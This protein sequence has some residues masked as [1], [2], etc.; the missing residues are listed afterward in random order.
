MCQQAVGNFDDTLERI[1]TQFYLNP[2]GTVLTGACDV[3]NTRVSYV[4]SKLAWYTNNPANAA[5]RAQLI[6][7][8][9]DLGNLNSSLSTYKI[10]SDRLSGVGPMSGSAAA[11]GC[12]LQDLLGSA[13]AP[14]QDVPD[15]DLQSLVTSLKQGEA[16]AAFKEKLSSAS[17]YSDYQQAMAT[18][19]STVNGF[20]TNSNNLFIP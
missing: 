13:C 15:I 3:A 8:K 4:D 16:I 20:N 5:I 2:I 7:E 12:S 6:Q 18:F 9:S 1:G 17:G 19:H 10:N 11:G 14:N